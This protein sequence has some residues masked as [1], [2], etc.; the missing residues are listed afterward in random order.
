MLIP[1]PEKPI[2]KVYVFCESNS[3][4]FWEKQSDGEDKKLSGC[5]FPRKEAGER[6][7]KGEEERDVSVQEN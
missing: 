3:T 5:Q 6:E 1:Q 7:R 2:C 4:T